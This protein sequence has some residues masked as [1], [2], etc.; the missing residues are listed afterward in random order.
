MIDFA[1]AR[2]RLLGTLEH[3]SFYPRDLIEQ[4]HGSIPAA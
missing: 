1:V 3:Y 4:A 2:E